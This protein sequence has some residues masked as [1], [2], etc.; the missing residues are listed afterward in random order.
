MHWRRLDREHTQAVLE[1]VKS[2]AEPSLFSPATSEVK[3]AI[4]SFYKDYKAF[5]VTNFASLPAFT[6]NYI[7]DGSFFHHMDGT[8]DAI[9]AVNDKGQLDLT[10]NTITDY[11]AFY[12][13]NVGLDDGEECY[14]IKNPEDM[15]LFESLDDDTIHAIMRNHEAPIVS[16]DAGQGI[17]TVTAELYVE[18]Q[19]NRATIEVKKNTGRVEIKDQTMIWNE[20]FDENQMESAF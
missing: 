7:G 1:S 9:F 17:F 12:F 6:F 18:G 14:F 13:A 15:P 8:S 4:L 19:V 16:F 5:E 20:L 2:A 3:S 10:E 11:L